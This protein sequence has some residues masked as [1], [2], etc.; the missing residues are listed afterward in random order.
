MNGPPEFIFQTPTCRKR[1]QRFDYSSHSSNCQYDDALIPSAASSTTSQQTAL[2]FDD[3]YEDVVFEAQQQRRTPMK[4]IPAS[5]PAKILWDIGTVILS[6]CNMYWTHCAIKERDF[7]RY[8]NLQLLSDLWFAVDICLN[9]MTETKLGNR[10]LT[11]FSA[12]AARYFCTWFL[13]DIMSLIPA[14]MLFVQPM[15]DKLKNRH[16]LRKLWNRSRAAI[17]WTFR[18]LVKWR[19]LSMD[20]TKRNGLGAAARLTRYCIKYI[21]KYWLFLRNMKGVV[22]ARLLRQVRCW[23]RFYK[24]LRVEDETSGCDPDWYYYH[25]PGGGTVLFDDELLDDGDPY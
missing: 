9:F 20:Y 15:I 12:V 7:D 1:K 24:R 19:S 2:S 5:H 4:L 23:R 11:T 21:P 3:D 25:A 8:W 6:V 22:A 10:T 14:E 18:V 16:R 13:I 17:R